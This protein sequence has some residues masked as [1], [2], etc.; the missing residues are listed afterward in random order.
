MSTRGAFDL[1]PKDVEDDAI[2]VKEKKVVK[3]PAKKPAAP[4]KKPAAPAKKEEPAK[5]APKKAEP[6]K[7]PAAPAKKPAAP[8]K[9]EE[10]VKPVPVKIAEHEEEVRPPR[11]GDRPPRAVRT[12]NRP[13]KREFDR[14]DGTGRAHEVKKGGAGR[15]NWSK[16]GDEAKEDVRPPRELT[17]EE[18]HEEEIRKI[19][20]QQKTYEQYASKKAMEKEVLVSKEGTAAVEADTTELKPIEREEFVVKKE[21]APKKKADKKKPKKVVAAPIEVSFAE[22]HRRFEREDRHE[23]KAA[24][25]SVEDET[26][27]PALD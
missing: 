23:K 25:A 10:P 15:G 19:R 7:K 3:K 5:P 27:F 8:A 14:H 4:A 20:A 12:G 22:G 21:E 11:R 9:K 6:A 17:E 2:V 18:K 16:P 26:A 1:L 13:P 24:K